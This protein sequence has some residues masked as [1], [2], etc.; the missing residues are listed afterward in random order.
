MSTP[1]TAVTTTANPATSTTSPFG[2]AFAYQPLWPFRSLDE[3]AAWQQAYRSGGHQ[4]WHLDA[5]ESALSLAQGF[6][7]FGEVDRTTSTTMD[8]DGAHVGVGFETEGGRTGTAAVLHLLRFGSGADA[9]GRWWAATTP[10]S[11]SP[12]PPTA[13]R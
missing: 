7:G 11:A 9:R 10:T 12:R 13:P 5:G 4:P 6:L 2:T 8:A 1:T 3:V